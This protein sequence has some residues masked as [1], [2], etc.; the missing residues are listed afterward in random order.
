MPLLHFLQRVS[1]PLDLC[2]LIIKLS[3]FI[4]QLDL[5]NLYL[6]SQFISLFFLVFEHPFLVA[7]LSKKF[8]SSFSQ[9]LGPILKLLNVF[10]KLLLLF[11]LFLQ[12]VLEFFLVCL[13]F[14][15]LEVF[16]LIEVLELGH[17]HLHLLLLCLQDGELVLFELVV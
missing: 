8:S 16:L 2:L 5:L 15:F 7:Q 10:I 3:L 4:L 11:Q 17:V 13:V 12:E 1:K 14:L 6:G 9:G